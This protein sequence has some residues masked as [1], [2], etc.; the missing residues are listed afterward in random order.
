MSVRQYSV[1]ELKAII[2]ESAT[3]FKPKMGQNVEKDNKSINDKAYKDMEKALK[4]YDGGARN[5]S[6]KK[7]QI[8]NDDNRGMQDLEYDNINKDFQKRVKSQMKG[9]TSHDA[10]EKHKKDPF[11]N[12]EFTEIQGMDDKNKALRKGKHIAK[13]IGLT[14]RE[15]NAKD[16]EDQTH[17]VFESQKITRLKF[18]NTSFLTEN[19][20][21]SKVPDDFKV[22]GRKFSMRDKHDNEYLVE[23]GETP[24]VSCV[25]KINEQKNRI[26][27]LFNY[28]RGESNT[29]CS[30]RLNEENNVSDMINRA[31]QLMK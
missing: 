31:R 17:S 7:P 30:S 16:I 22:E 20:M 11:G 14:S 15:L 25:T 13:E 9:Y 8:P 23:W 3:E 19:H 10:E 2:S 26:Q 6:K 12:A 24:K 28:K 4:S 29:T 1:R 27:E 18:K 5:E 21:L